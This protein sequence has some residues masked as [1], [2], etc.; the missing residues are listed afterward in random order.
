MIAAPQNDEVCLTQITDLVRELAQQRDPAFVGLAESYPTTGD[1]INHLRSLPQ[2]DDT[3]DP[4]DGPRAA[5]CQPTQRVRL[6]PIPPDPNC[7]ERAAIY[8]GVAELIDPGPVRQLRT[9]D[10]P[11]GLHTFPVENTRAVVLDPRMSRNALQA[12]IFQALPLAHP[13]TPHEAIDWL[14]SMAEEPATRVVGGLERVQLSHHA[15]Y[16]LLAGELLSERAVDDVAYTCA[17]ALQEAHYYGAA[18]RALLR[19]TIRAIGARMPRYAE[20]VIGPAVPIPYEAELRNALSLQ[21][22]P[23]KINP[24]WEALGAVGRVGLNLGTQVGTAA[25]QAKLASLGL[26]P[27]VMSV[28]EHEF[29]REGISLGPLA[30]RAPSLAALALLPSL[31]SLTATKAAAA[32]STAAATRTANATMGSLAGPQAVA[33][34]RNSFIATPGVILAEMR[35]TDGD[36]KALG[37]DI[38]AAFRRPFEDQQTKAEALFEQK[39]GRIP[40]AGIASKGPGDPGTGLSSEKQCEPAPKGDP[41]PDVPR[42]RHKTV[43]LTAGVNDFISA[44]ADYAKVW[45]SMSPVPTQADIDSKSYQGAFVRQ[46]GEFM[47]QWE[48]WY[49]DNDDLGARMWGSTRDTALDYRKRAQAW[50]E[51]FL[52]LGGVTN[53]PAPQMPTPPAILGGLSNGVKTAA[54]VLGGA[55][56]AALVLPPLLRRST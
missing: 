21:I 5:A 19:E 35:I 49:H 23:Y 24:N 43:K 27:P 45:A 52:A 14:V 17:L 1:L 47:Q 20:P 16:A 40:G 30:P 34:L 32:G 46:W 18:G 51:K 26:T 56:A 25:L 37:R 10:T 28:L 12:S 36:I 6:S 8:A 11:F 4:T 38:A 41:Y 13:V 55:V 48:T 3:G 33:T 22:G 42:C 31:S 54:V 15:M 2:R 9:E 50:R 29:N 39:Y 44:E 53:A 7:V